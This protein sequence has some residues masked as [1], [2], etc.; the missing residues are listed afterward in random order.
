[1][2]FSIGTSAVVYPAADLARAAR[3][4][5]AKIV[6]INAQATPLTPL[7][8]WALTGRSGELLPVLIE[9]AFGS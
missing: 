1:L 7:A 2:F 6:E 4:S 9:R 3:R 5:G 8:D